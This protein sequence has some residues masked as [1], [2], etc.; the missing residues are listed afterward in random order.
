MIYIY[1]NTH[2]RFITSTNDLWV[3]MMTAKLMSSKMSLCVVDDQLNNLSNNECITWGL[4]NPGEAKQNQQ[5][6]S[7]LIS[8]QGIEFKGDVLD[9]EVSK[10]VEYQKTTL[11]V[12]NIL[13]SA[14]ITDALHNT[15]DQNT[16]LK[17]FNDSTFISVNDDSGVEG[18]FLLSI[19]KIVYLSLSLE[20]MYSKI[21]DIL[22]DPKSS[23]PTNLNIYRTAFYKWL[24]K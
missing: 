9:I 3:T 15:V 7:L 24:E 1:S 22:N 18:G 5:N 20:E 23:R 16:F 8:Q 21:D 13:R 12:Y 10:L 2:E 14:W 17:L 19:Y 11:G 6:P 4:V